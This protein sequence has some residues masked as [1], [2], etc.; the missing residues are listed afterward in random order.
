MDGLTKW[1]PNWKRNGWKTADKK[2]VKNGDLWRAWTKRPSAT[3]S[4]GA[5]CAG[6]RAMPKTN[7]PT[8]WRGGDTEH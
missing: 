2:P 4:S 3:T 7:A 5:G 8:H 1:L 6:H